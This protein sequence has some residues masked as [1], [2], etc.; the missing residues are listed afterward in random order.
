MT[1]S[2]AKINKELK[3]LKVNNYV[4]NLARLGISSGAI[5]IVLKKSKNFLIIVPS[6]RN[7]ISIDYL[8]ASGVEIEYV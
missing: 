5:C 1:L 2:D 7:A 8:V 3:I 4:L 6:F